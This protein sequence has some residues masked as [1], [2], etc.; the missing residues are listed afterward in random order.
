MGAYAIKNGSVLK[1]PRTGDGSHGCMNPVALPNGEVVENPELARVLQMGNAQ[2][3]AYVESL[4]N[5][6]ASESGDRRL[7]KPLPSKIGTPDW[8]QERYIDY[9]GRH[10]GEHGASYYLNYGFKYC[11]RFSEDVY[12]R[13]TQE[14]QH[15]LVHARTNLQVALEDELISDPVGYDEMEQDD[16]ELEDFAFETHAK[17]YLDAGLAS[18]P[19]SDLHVIA[20]TP[21][22]GDLFTRAGLE[23]VGRTAMDASADWIKGLFEDGPKEHLLGEKDHPEVPYSTP[24]DEECGEEDELPLFYTEFMESRLEMDDVR[25]S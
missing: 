24:T 22:L 21:D 14:G 7:P 18:L 10:P 25:T 8:Y 13:L 9:V 15:W 11:K 4:R 17:A 20:T 16:A 6:P 3:A 19:V 23:Q 5:A 2:A 12:P 1:S